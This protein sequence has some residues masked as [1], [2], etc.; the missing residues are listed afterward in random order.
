MNRVIQSHLA[1]SN[2]DTTGVINVEDGVARNLKTSQEFAT[3]NHEI[4]DGSLD[5]RKGT[6]EPGSYSTAYNEN[7]PWH[8]RG[9]GKA[10]SVGSVQQAKRHGNIVGGKPRTTAYNSRAIGTA[11]GIPTIGA[12][13]PSNVSSNHHQTNKMSRNAD[14]LG[15]GY[16]ADAAAADE[17]AEFEDGSNQ[18]FTGRKQKQS[19]K[20]R[21]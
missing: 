14:P 9:K 19:V 15:M 7:R 16:G 20:D 5:R 13:K 2:I 1:D 11:P 8:K 12:F 17:I 6:G 10:Q 18:D 3:I 4:N 21:A